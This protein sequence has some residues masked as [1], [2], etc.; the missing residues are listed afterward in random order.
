MLFDH[1]GPTPRILAGAE[2]VRAI[3]DL[4]LAWLI[5]ASVDGT[6]S[7]RADVRAPSSDRCL[8][9]LRAA[10]AD[11]DLH[12]VTG[13]RGRASVRATDGTA[14]TALLI[15]VAN[16]CRRMRAHFWLERLHQTAWLAEVELTLPCETPMPQATTPLA[17][18]AEAWLIGQPPRALEST[19]GR[20]RRLGWCVR[21][22]AHAE[23]AVQ[24]LVRRPPAAAP[25]LVIGVGHL[26]VNRASIAH[27]RRE[28]PAS[29][30]LAWAV[31]VS[32]R[33]WRIDIAGVDRFAWPLSETRLRTLT[34]QARAGAAAVER[35][36]RQHALRVLVV[37]D[38]ELNRVVAG[39]MLE[40]LGYEAQFAADGVEGL[41]RCLT[42]EPDLVLMNL[43]MP[44]LDGLDATFKLR[45]WQRDGVVPRFPIV[46][47]TSLVADDERWDRARMEMDAV[48][49]KPFD[50]RT[51][52]RKLSDLLGPVRPRS[53]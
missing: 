28:M 18:A 42:S 45:R 12:Q 23:D 27:L 21:L 4:L 35:V 17:M 33:R 53:G 48:L 52:Q 32:A 22:F 38:D 50:Q 15:L 34:D 39:A 6:G 26:G 3:V 1:Q 41:D 43:N 29:V 31:D 40:A 14:Q 5:R 36:K 47:A 8:V 11:P 7:L 20:L 13:G 49:T 24:R 9:R 25:C 30:R 10:N 16:L 46:A 44:R 2:A 37:D 51:L 19:L